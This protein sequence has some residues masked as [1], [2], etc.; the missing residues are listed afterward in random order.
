[1]TEV[2]L[3]R[4]T[5]GAMEHITPELARH[6]AC[7]A[8]VDVSVDNAFYFDDIVLRVMQAVY[9]ET[10]ESVECE[11]PADWWQAFKGRWF[12]GWALRRWPVRLDGATLEARAMYPKVS[13]PEE[14]HKIV[15]DAR[16]RAY[17]R[18]EI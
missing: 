9:G 2:E 8:R 18:G 11:W 6:F 17:E 12:P 3:E 7:P 14:P 1:M 13:M 10:L 5:L 16:H 4:F 15:L